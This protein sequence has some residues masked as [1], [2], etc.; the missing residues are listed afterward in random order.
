MAYKKVQEIGKGGFGIVDEVEDDNSNRWAR[1][2]FAP[3]S[4][5]G[6]SADDLRA[7]FER[8]V[9]YQSEIDHANVVV[10]HD[11]DL[12]ANP[13][14]FIMELADGTLAEEINA[15]RTLGGDPRKPLFD[16]LAGLEA[17]HGKGYKHRDL[18]PK[19]V[20]RFGGAAPRYAI[21]D[22]GLMSVTAGQTTTLTATNQA[23]G[24]LHYQSPEC[25][26]DVKRATTQSDIYSFGALLHDI[27]A[28]GAARVP[29]TELTVAGP[30]GPIIEKCTKRN[31]HRRYKSVAALREDLYKVLSTEKVIFASKE[32]AEIV[33]LLEG[34]SSLTDDEWDRVF[35]QM[36]ENE[37]HHR[38]NH[39][40]YR[41][42]S[43]DHLLQLAK[44]ATELLMALGQGYARYAQTRSFDFDYCDVLASKAEVF[45]EH[46]EL[47]L[48]AF[49]A[50]AML[51][52]GTSHNRWFVE[53]VFMEMAG[54]SISD[55]LANRIKVEIEVQSV[56]F[57]S[58][59]RHLERSISE[60][61]D[62]LHPVLREILVGCPE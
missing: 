22:F 31:L 40:I 20:L 58:R 55:A 53:R 62:N 43:H 33:T 47:D 32:E 48:Q 8:E 9:R 19:N 16:I 25:A 13:P 27:F 51:E 12:A 5:P 45:Y 35:L 23:G 26:I 17:I 44:D 7:R 21:S 11:Y 36:D 18:N 57:C 56:D 42:L 1:K 54:A 4:I 49:I 37:D 28:G 50:L 61:R 39:A 6:I 3:P 59:I 14:W 29:H 10:I 15:D 41:A 60:R 24:T 30:L 46:G 38:S 52:L 2:T 34:K